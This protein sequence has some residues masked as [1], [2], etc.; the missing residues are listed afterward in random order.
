MH[1]PYVSKMTKCKL[2]TATILFYLIVHFILAEDVATGREIS[3][4][5]DYLA[6]QEI[7]SVNQ[8]DDHEH[9]T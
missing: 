2:S 9:R 1:S 8:A 6:F 7:T 4:Y 5:V 3:S